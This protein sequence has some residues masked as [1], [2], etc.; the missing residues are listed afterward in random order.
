MKGL[1]TGKGGPSAGKKELLSL[2]R[3]EDEK[4]L[5]KLILYLEFFKIMILLVSFLPIFIF[6]YLILGPSATPPGAGR[7]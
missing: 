3:K 6:F 2:G 4:T 7:K 1:F 5:F